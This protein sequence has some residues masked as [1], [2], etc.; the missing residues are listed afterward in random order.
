[1]LTK[2]SVGLADKLMTAQR[3]AIQVLAAVALCMPALAAAQDDDDRGQY[4]LELVPQ[5]RDLIAA[6]SDLDAATSG[7]SAS[8]RQ[9]VASNS[10]IAA[11]AS[12]K[13]TVLSVASDVLFAFDRATLSAKAQSTLQDIAAI[14]A[15]I[16][17][18]SVKV[19]GHTD[20]V[21]G[22]DYNKTLSAARAEAVVAFLVAHGVD[23]SR[24]APAGHGETEPVAENEINGKDNPPGRARNR[25]VEFVLPK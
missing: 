13:G 14:V 10:D 16:P 20:S 17:A 6:D 11:R 7:L 9:L 21:G 8:A 1:M 15:D 4:I 22:V 24:L 3:L 19:I 23:A 12:D 18:G 2:L 5:I 25:R